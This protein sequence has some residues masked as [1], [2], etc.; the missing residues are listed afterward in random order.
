MRGCKHGAFVN[1]TD[2]LLTIDVF[3]SSSSFSKVIYCKLVHMAALLR[4]KLKIN[5][6][7]NTRL[8]FLIRV[9]IDEYPE[10]P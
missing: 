6:L 1:S 8:V 3:L 4:K 10:Y 9:I 5:F 2:L 7:I